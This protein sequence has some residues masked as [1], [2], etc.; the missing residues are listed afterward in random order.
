M[1]VAG[2]LREEAYKLFRGTI[3]FIAGCSTSVGNEQEDVLL[4]DD[5]VINKT[6]PLI[7]CAEEDVVGNHGATIGRLDEALIFYMET[8]GMQR[9]E[10]YEMMAKARIDALIRKLP[11]AK[12]REALSDT[13]ETE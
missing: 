13:E 9:E 11:D 8:R 2:V 6:I 10:L 1:D 4:L 7:L 3:D 5:T 12:M